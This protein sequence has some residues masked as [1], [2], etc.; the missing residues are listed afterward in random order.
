[1]EPNGL[2]PT[3]PQSVFAGATP[4]QQGWSQPTLAPRFGDAPLATSTT[5]INFEMP[6]NRGVALA[7]RPDEVTGN[8]YSTTAIILGS[9]AFIL[10]PPILGGTGLILAAIGKSKGESRAVV[11]MVVSA[12]GL[13]LGTCLGALMFGMPI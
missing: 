8:G 3:S 7:V 9:I 11:G 1:M 6:Q 2:P 5:T 10:F 12:L 4:P 13:V